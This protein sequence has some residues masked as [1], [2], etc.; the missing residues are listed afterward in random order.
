[1]CQSVSL[2]A[3]PLDYSEHLVVPHRVCGEVAEENKEGE[4]EEGNKE[5]EEGEEGDEAEENKEKEEEEDG[6][7]AEEKKRKEEEQ[8]GEVAE[9]EK[10]GEGRCPC[11]PTG[12]RPRAHGGTHPCPPPLSPQM[13]G[14]VCHRATN[15]YDDVF[16]PLD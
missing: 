13:V 12:G 1:M 2:S 16:A 11:L 7:V 15:G 9:E 5:K 10:E 4:V 8:C 3:V 14:G 6:D